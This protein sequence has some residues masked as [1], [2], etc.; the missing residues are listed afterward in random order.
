[1]P[2]LNLY[3]HISLGTQPMME[4]KSSGLLVIWFADDP[5]VQVTNSSI[6]LP[7]DVLLLQHCPETTTT[8]Y[9]TDCQSQALVLFIHC[10]RAIKPMLPEWWPTCA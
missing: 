7:S 4:V 6:Q 10:C 8:H 5:Q 9:Y 2:H 1:M 3:L